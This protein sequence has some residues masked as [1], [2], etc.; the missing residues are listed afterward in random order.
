MHMYWH[1][2]TN[3][4]VCFMTVFGLKQ[5]KMCTCRHIQY[6]YPFASGSLSLLVLL[7]L[8]PWG[9]LLRANWSSYT[10]RHFHATIYHS[11]PTQWLF[12]SGLQFTQ[13]LCACRQVTETQGYTH[14]GR[15]SCLP[16]DRSHCHTCSHTQTS[17]TLIFRAGRIYDLF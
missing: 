13:T 7:P 16:F 14:T 12:S 1:R 2:H 11:T 4:R 9:Q 3:T 10:C 6:M 8:F 5:V 15:P 17:S